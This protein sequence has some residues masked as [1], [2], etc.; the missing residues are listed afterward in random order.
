MRGGTFLSRGSLF[1]ALLFICLIWQAPAWI[2]DSALDRSTDG[3]VRLY[4]SSGSLWSGNGTLTIVDPVRRQTQ[5][6]FA[7]GWSWRASALFRG[8]AAWRL[9]AD[10]RPAGELGLGIRGWRAEG[11]ALAAPARFAFERIPH[12]FGSLG[13][14][15][16]IQ[17]ET[18]L[19]RCDWHQLCE[20][21]ADLRWTGAAVDVLRGHLLGDYL[22]TAR[23]EGPRISF[24]WNTP[25]GETRIEASG[26]LQADRHWHFAGSVT[27]DP[28][29]LQRLPAVAGRWVQA[30]GAPGQ[31]R[32]DVGG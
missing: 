15:G 13:W 27:G 19:W 21:R 18:T 17:L 32:F 11:V 4:A 10:G 14:R 30:T 20:G 3:A 6:W 8:E 5:P 24:D 12:A 26:F 22:M 28:V 16:D 2:V 7:L 29:F 25:N 23:G 9:T 1:L 31:Y